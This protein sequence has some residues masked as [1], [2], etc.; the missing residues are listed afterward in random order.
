MKINEILMFEAVLA[1]LSVCL[2]LNVCL[3]HIESEAMHITTHSTDFAL[4][5]ESLI[6][7]I[8]FTLHYISSFV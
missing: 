1:C 6:Q 2:S 3:Q 4:L 7:C 8:Y 5:N